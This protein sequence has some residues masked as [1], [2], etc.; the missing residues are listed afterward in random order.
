MQIL[1]N[2]NNEG[3]WNSCLLGVIWNSL[4]I[5]INFHHFE[6][7][8]NY[9]PNNRIRLKVLNSLKTLHSLKTFPQL[10]EKLENSLICRFPSLPL[11]S[12]YGKPWSSVSIKKIHKE[13]SFFVLLYVPFVGFF[14]VIVGSHF[15]I[16]MH[17]S[18]FKMFMLFVC[19]F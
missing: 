7:S 4:N 11:S 13:F 5:L 15:L 6:Y 19:V 17:V 14:L 8:S 18:M 10:V 2:Y 3:I 16:V 9:Y 1:K 12:N